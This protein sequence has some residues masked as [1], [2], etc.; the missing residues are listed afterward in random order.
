MTKTVLITGATD[1][2]G[3]LAAKT[4]AEKGHNLLVHGRSSAKLSSAVEEVQS[5]S[6]GGSVTGLLADLSKKA[7]V[8]SLACQVIS[9]TNTLDVLI[10]NAGVFRSDE[11]VSADGIDLRFAVNTIAPAILTQKVLAL[12]TRGARVIS[13]SS[14][15]QAPVDTNALVGKK[16]VADQFD[17][18]A[19]SKLALTL[20]SQDMS[21]IHKELIFVSLNPG[22]LLATKMVQEGFGVSG[23]DLS[24]G[25]DVIVRAALDAEFAEASGLYFDNDI[26][27]FGKP[28]PDAMDEHKVEAV[29]T[30]IQK[31]VSIRA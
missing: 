17:A 28:H 24:I 14:A 4:L 25:S 10:N 7:D 1:G 3:L 30:A 6:K 9:T 22:S 15:A 13:L 12:L 23:K 21:M 29:V 11:S 26:G 5:V 20:W 16:Q 8:E 31:A 27:T 19:Q 2:I 18:Y